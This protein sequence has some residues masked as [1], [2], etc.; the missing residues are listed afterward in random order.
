MCQ[1]QVKQQSGSYQDKQALYSEKPVRYSKIAILILLG[2]KKIPD[3]RQDDTKKCSINK[4]FT[5]KS[6]HEILAL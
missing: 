1:H 4:Q 6:N 3:G 2:I 5:D